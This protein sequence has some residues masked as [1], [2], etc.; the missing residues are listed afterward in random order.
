[1][2]ETPVEAPPGDGLPMHVYHHAGESYRVLSGVMKVNIEGQWKRVAVGE[3][4]T[5]PAGKA[6]TLR[7]SAPVVLINTHKPAPEFE[8]FFRRVHKLVTKQGVRL[9]PKVLK[10]AVLTGMLFAAH[11]RE[12]VTEQPPQ[13]VMRVLATLGRL[14]GHRLPDWAVGPAPSAGFPPGHSSHH[15]RECRRFADRPEPTAT[16]LRGG[17]RGS[18]RTRGRRRRPRRSPG[19]GRNRG[20]RRC[21]WWRPA[22]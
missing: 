19:S 9:P 21:R 7:N 12:N 6:H 17:P 8:R 15:R 5:V 14:L 2:F 4:L 18:R 16:T 3:A 11:E 13:V 20:P 10:S 1:M 22:L